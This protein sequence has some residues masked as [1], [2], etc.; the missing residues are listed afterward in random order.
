MASLISQY[1]IKL[2]INIVLP[3]KIQL[4]PFIIRIKNN[5]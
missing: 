4:S 5:I 1:K 3:T 2:F